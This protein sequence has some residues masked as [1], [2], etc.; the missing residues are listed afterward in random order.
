MRRLWALL[1]LVGLFG[2][3]AGAT[4]P[5]NISYTVVN[6]DSTM[7]IQDS[8]DVYGA[9]ETP[10]IF[11]LTAG[12][13]RNQFVEPYSHQVFWGED[14]ATLNGSIDISDSVW[15]ADPGRGPSGQTLYA[16]KLAVSDKSDTSNP[17]NDCNDDFDPSGCA[18]PFDLFISGTRQ[19]RQ[20][21]AMESLYIGSLD[22]PW[23]WYYDFAGDTAWAVVPPNNLE[24]VE[25]SDHATVASVDRMAFDGRSRGADSVYIVNLTIEKYGTKGRRSAIHCDRA[26][27]VGWVVQDCVIQYN[28]AGGVIVGP[29]GHI[30]RCVVRSNGERGTALGIN[31][32]SD[33]HG[34]TMEGCDISDNNFQ[35]FLFGGATKN[36]I[37]I[38][39]ALRGNYVHDNR[40]H[41]LWI[42]SSTLGTSNK[43]VIENNLITDN[44][45]IGI[46]Y[47]ISD[48]AFIHHNVLTNNGSIDY[49]IYGDFS[50]KYASILISESF[51]DIDV[52]WNTITVEDGF[53]GSGIRLR[54]FEREAHEVLTDVD[55]KYNTTT[56]E[57]TSPNSVNRMFGKISVASYT[58]DDTLIY[59]NQAAVDYDFNTYGTQ[60]TTTDVFWWWDPAST[61]E[62]AMNFNEWVGEDSLWYTHDLDSD[63]VLLSADS[64]ATKEAYIIVDNRFPIN[65]SEQAIIDRLDTVFGITLVVV[66]DDVV[67]GVDYSTTD[68]VIVSKTILSTNVGDHFK[69]DTFGV[70]FWEDN[71][72]MHSQ[73]GTID[74]D[75]SGGTAW[76]SPETTLY[77]LPLAPA[78]LRGGQ[79]GDITF[80]STTEELTWAPRA[81]LDT[82]VNHATAVA[83]SSNGAGTWPIYVFEV[84]DTCYTAAG[85]NEYEVLGRRSYFGLYDDSFTSLTN[86]ALDV[87]DAHILWLLGE[88]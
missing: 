36:D 81:D 19:L 61:A 30:S 45:G 1:A 55:I 29:G 60:D 54:S 64:G 69:D 59:Y 6:L 23:Q 80:Y 73:M 25:F 76:H 47:E 28:H 78:E 82:T 62:R 58:E 77:I 14:G 21:S 10:V 50:D 16:L 41:G 52:M 43:N 8:A 79:S 56:F 13:Y 49:G 11:V 2:I 75:G 27:A 17:L 71:M 26:N 15:T 9:A 83:E 51:G 35:R 66:N 31:T 3:L 63:W 85:V 32:G 12:V 18:Y 88:T 87:F 5:P 20:V 24:P 48:S 38:G 39:T 4:L 40:E 46:Y 34:G 33:Y 42:D 37:S 72:Q 44:E 86:D 74:N 68:L 70:M 53:P 7:T 22:Y 65:A 84:G 67:T 57:G